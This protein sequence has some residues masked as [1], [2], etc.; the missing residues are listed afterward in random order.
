MDYKSLNCLY[1]EQVMFRPIPP[2]PRRQVLLEQTNAFEPG[3]QYK[4]TEFNLANPTELFNT[5]DG[6][7]GRGEYS[8][9]CIFW[10]VSSY[11][12]LRRLEAHKAAE[13]KRRSFSI[14]QG[15]GVS[16][17]VLAPDGGHYEVKEIK[18]VTDKEGKKTKTVRTGTNG[19]QAATQV[20]NAVN[21]FLDEVLRAYDSMDDSSKAA[22]NDAIIKNP[23]TRIAV[24][25]QYQDRLEGWT[26]DKYIHTILSKS[27]VELSQ[28]ILLGDKLAL[29]H[30]KLR[31]ALIFSLKQFADVLNDV[32]TTTTPGGNNTN[33]KDLYDTIL[34]NYKINADDQQEKD[35]F[36]KEARNIDRSITQKQCRLFK[37][38]TNQD[39]FKQTIKSLNLA[40][41]LEEIRTALTNVIFNT[42]PETGLFIVNSDVFVYIPKERLGEFIYANQISAGAPKIGL[43]EPLKNL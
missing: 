20:I 8:L 27:N 14:I 42:F 30:Y 39:S 13:F 43:K 7:V 18:I 25:P 34:K 36:E 22:I 41:G 37:K 16:F 23:I 3:R 19:K 33:I 28:G 38:C 5:I 6:G 24:G 4:W 17:D 32:V 21:G 2:L 31:P 9:A 29:G 1:T 11:D 40:Q 15:S 26:I 35:F 12:A 10:G